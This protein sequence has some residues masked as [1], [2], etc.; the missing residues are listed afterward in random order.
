M[1]TTNSSKLPFFAFGSANGRDD[2]HNDKSNSSF[3]NKDSSIAALEA[4]QREYL[5][6]TSYPNPIT[7]RIPSSLS[8]GRGSSPPRL[9]SPGVFPSPSTPRSSDSFHQSQNY[10]EQ[11]KDVSTK[12][13]ILDWLLTQKKTFLIYNTKTMRRHIF[14]HS[15]HSIM[16][17]L[18]WR[19]HKNLA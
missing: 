18:N 3:Y 7:Q 4:F 2:N 15:L 13:N 17:N 8:G 19:K 12:Y 11:F 14:L 1:Q 10:D 6:K 16:G 5:P 9:P